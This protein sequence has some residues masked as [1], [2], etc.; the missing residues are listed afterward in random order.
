M[1]NAEIL[2]VLILFIY[3]AT[4]VYRLRNVKTH[5]D[6]MSYDDGW[7][8]ARNTI[9]AMVLIVVLAFSVIYAIITVNSFVNSL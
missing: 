3:I 1:T 6:F 2:W 4:G 7:T 8:F 5:D 9:L